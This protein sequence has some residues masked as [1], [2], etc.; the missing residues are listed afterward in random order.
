MAVD[1]TC[2]RA[3][4]ELSSFTASSTIRRFGRA[5]VLR[6]AVARSILSEEEKE[7]GREQ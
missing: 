2:E 5:L 4:T 1:S 7:G 6:M 3:T